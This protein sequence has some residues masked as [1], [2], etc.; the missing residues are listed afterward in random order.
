[1][2]IHYDRKT[3]RIIQT[4]QDRLHNTV[5]EA[6]PPTVSDDVEM[7]TL[8]IQFVPAGKNQPYKPK[9]EPDQ[10]PLVYELERTGN[11]KDFKVIDNKLV[12]SPQELPE[13]AAVTVIVDLKPSEEEVFNKFSPDIQKEIKQAEKELVFRVGTH[14]D[15]DKY[16]AV[17]EEMKQTK[18]LFTS[19]DQYF[20]PKFLAW[21]FI[22]YFAEDQS[23]KSLAGALVLPS[24][25]PHYHSA[26]TTSEGRTKYAGFFLLWNIIK[27]LKKLG[28]ESLNLGGVYN[29]NTKTPL[30]EDKKNVNLYKQKWGGV[31]VTGRQLRDLQKGK[32]PLEKLT[33]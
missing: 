23:G 29:E 15:A 8:V 32:T 21:R 1:M 22:I 20:T 7:G 4:V 26:A 24:R 2:I 5:L 28:F 31:P 25:I 18:K 27:D 11:V 6:M 16:L 3:G 9:V 33:T 19:A 10:E 13:E 17:F 14:L 30:E 12:K